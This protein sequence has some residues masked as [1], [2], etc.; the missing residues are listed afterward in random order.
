MADGETLESGAQYHQT[1]LPLSKEADS[2]SD[3]VALGTTDKRETPGYQYQLF[4]AVTFNLININYIVKKMKK[5][6]K[7]QTSLDICRCIEV[8]MYYA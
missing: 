8:N 2:G 4:S 7:P 5:Y 3:T 1:D 6:L